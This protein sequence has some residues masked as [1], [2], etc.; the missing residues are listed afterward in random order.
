MFH[1]EYSKKPPPGNR[2]YMVNG[3]CADVGGGVVTFVTYDYGWLA[4][5]KKGESAVSPY[6][7]IITLWP[8]TVDALFPIVYQ[9][10]CVLINLIVFSTCTLILCL[11]CL[12]GKPILSSGCVL[13]FLAWI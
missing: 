10:A 9:D 6:N 4:S 11:I 12:L 13:S 7:T 8:S 1:E 2:D 3:L 5:F